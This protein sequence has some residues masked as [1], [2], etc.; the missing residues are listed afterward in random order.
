MKLA[1]FDLDHTLLPFD[2]G[3]AWTRFLV[4]RGVLPAGAADDY[5]QACQ[6]YVD[7]TLDIRQLHRQTV[8]PLA[9][10]GATELQL[11]ANAFG[12][13]LEPRIPVPH[14]AWVE[15][16]RRQQHTCVLV[17]ATTHF[18]AAAVA[19]RFGIDEVLATRSSVDADGRLN[20]AIDGE[21]CYGE[22]KL[23]QV[24][25]WLVARGA[26]LAD[27]ERSWFYSDSITDLP[28]LRAVSDP[29]AVR[30]DARLRALATSEGWTVLEGGCDPG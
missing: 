5:L 21:P 27:C 24:Q 4:G 29:V 12:S 9:G 13:S 15:R 23:V 16:H 3:M 18:I 20:G 11:L 17:T 28:L 30:P 14:R 19:P 1:L 22:Q 7:G 10:L 25:R 2:S 8:T 26:T 6:R